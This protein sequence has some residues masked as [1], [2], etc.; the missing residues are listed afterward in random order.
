M[1]AAPLGNT[2]SADAVQSVVLLARSECSHEAP[3]PFGFGQ[4]IR[5]FALRLCVYWLLSICNLSSFY[6]TFQ[7]LAR[8]T[9]SPSASSKSVQRRARPQASV[10]ARRAS[11]ENLAGPFLFLVSP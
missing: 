6:K 1:T 10:P 2:F 5:A 4:Y 3:K 7:F 9:Q 8:L 11:G